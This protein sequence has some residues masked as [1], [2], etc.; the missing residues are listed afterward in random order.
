ML[1]NTVFAVSYHAKEVAKVLGIGG[2]TLRKWCLEFERQNYLFERGVN[3]T[4]YFKERDLMLL[5][6]VKEQLQEHNETLQDAVNLVL[7]GIEQEQ[8]ATSVIVD[9]SKEQQVDE[10]LVTHEDIEEIKERLEE[11]AEFNKVLLN[12]LRRQ[13]EQQQKAL[14]NPEKQRLERFNSLVAER[15]VVRVLEKEALALWDAKSHEDRFI[16][17]GWFR[18]IEDFDKRD[19]FVKSYVDEHFE[20]RLSLEFGFDGGNSNDQN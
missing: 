20:E 14:P 11:Q 17:L 8:R 2:S 4:R 7:T 15:R 13:Q 18:K 3:N 5:H 19:R 6:R 9:Y 16:K 12:E 10:P 1:T